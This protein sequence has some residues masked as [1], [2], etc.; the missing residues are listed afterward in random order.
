VA[1]QETLETLVPQ[2]QEEAVVAVAVAALEAQMG[3]Q[4][5]GRALE[6]PEE[7][8]VDKALKVLQPHNLLYLDHSLVTLWAVQVAVALGQQMMGNQDLL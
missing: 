3:L 1:Q 8:E 6:E 2:V 7:P 4:T 5:Q